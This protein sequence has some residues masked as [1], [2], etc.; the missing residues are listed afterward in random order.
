MGARAVL[1]WEPDSPTT[2]HLCPTLAKRS[3]DFSMEETGLCTG[4]YHCMS[5]ARI[6]WP[7]KQ[8]QGESKSEVEGS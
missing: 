2:G 6:D 3:K 1:K 7:A 4:R 8:N 5:E